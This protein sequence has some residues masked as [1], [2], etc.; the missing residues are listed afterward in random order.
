ML[1]NK[2]PEKNTMNKPN[3]K[4]SF[5]TLA[6]LA[7]ANALAAPPVPDAGQIS[8]DLQNQPD[9]TAPKS[10]APLRVEG[11]ALPPGAKSGD[12]RFA[13][14]TLHVTG[15][16]AF[17]AQELEALVQDLAGA[18]HSLAELTAGAG[19]IT[20]YYRAHGFV[21]AR[22]YLPAQDIKDGMVVIHVLEGVLDQK[23]LSNK[24][25]LSDDQVNRY[26]ADLKS[27]EP[28]NSNQVDRALLLLSDAPGVG[29]ARAALQPGAS[30]GSADLLLELDPAQPYAANLEFD[31]YGNRYTG[32]YRAGA[33]LVL[34]NPLRLGDLASVRL[35]TS[36]P[37]MTYA[38][39]AYQV[40][41][42]MR[43][44]KV[45]VAYSDTGYRLGQEFDSLQAHGT[46]D[47][48]S[49]YAT[50]PLQRSQLSNLSCTVSWEG[51][52]LVDQTDTVANSTVSKQVDLLTLGLTGSQ[53]DAFWGGGLTG[54][55]V[56]LIGG[57]LSMDAAS[58]ALDT[59]AGSSFT[60]GS[61][62]KLTYSV[63]RQQRVNDKYSMLLALSGQQASKNLN[64]SEKFSLGGANGVRAYPQGEASG[65]DGILASLEARRSVNEQI[66]AVLFYDAGQV[67]TNR[68]PYGV[69]AA[70]NTRF[71]SGA[72]FGLNGAIGKLQFKSS[73]A[74]ITSGGDPVSD[75][76]NRTPRLW[77]QLSLPL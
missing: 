47:S 21:V 75:T 76:A 38:R 70:A 40:P 18:E 61:F 52:K 2:L 53:Q 54:F 28:I 3:I 25:D 65:D 6:V 32:E 45:G 27:G 24:S 9:L 46:A 33:A 35:T 73:L 62:S 69:V 36:G 20:A 64:S 55:D 68:N 67:D 63:N 60:D 31:N 29:A 41:V 30:V 50:Y 11:Q 19:R 72:G 59:A 34:N 13:V 66:Q 22:A 48:V 16:S 8:R 14:K 5:V 57:S 12:I 39:V 74:W 51:K 49:L 1:K 71:I 4:L 37:D 15:S 44:L 77:F 10:V 42:G 26:F 58:L 7:C 23:R 17:S 56:A 43:G